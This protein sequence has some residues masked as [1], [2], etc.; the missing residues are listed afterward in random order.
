MLKKEKSWRDGRRRRCY[1]SGS[2][3]DGISIG[4]IE[5]GTHEQQNVG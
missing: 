3:G 1:Q 4:G 5:A 2:D